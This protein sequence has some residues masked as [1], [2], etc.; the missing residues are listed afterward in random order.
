MADINRW[1]ETIN[2]IINGIK[3]NQY[4]SEAAVSRGIAMRIFQLLN[5]PIYSTNIVYPEFPLKM[6][7]VDYALCHPKNNPAVIVEVKAL[8]K[9]R[10]GDEQ[11]FDYAFHAGVPIAILTDGKEWHFYFPAGR[12]PIEERRF[13]K[14][15]IMERKI[16]EIQN[17]FERYL[18]YENVCSGKS[19]EYAQEDYN[20]RIRMETTKQ[21]I[22]IAWNKLVEERAPE[23]IEIISEKVA[24]ICGIE[25]SEEDIMSFLNSLTHL[26]QSSETNIQKKTIIIPLEKQSI[27]KVDNNY[28]GNMIESF[29]DRCLI[30]KIYR[31]TIIDRNGSIYEA[32]RKKWKLSKD[33]AEQADYILALEMDSGLIKGIYAANKWFPDGNRYGFEGTEITEGSVVE[34][35]LNKR[36]PINYIKTGSQNP[37]RYTW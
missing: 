13:Y 29:P 15:D 24:D 28:D 21:N 12:G 18:K 20:N 6:R 2:E 14:I 23:L 22:P 1:D 10:G 25:A 31:K 4:S 11:L 27:N 36:L 26:I 30:I 7:N 37:I 5:W 34:R 9:I 16:E 35:Y 32:V 17:R 8:D 33:K 3:E 19:Y